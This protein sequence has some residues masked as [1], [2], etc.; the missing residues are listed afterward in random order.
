MGV[1]KRGYKR[2]VLGV[3]A[4]EWPGI[5]TLGYV[6]SLRKIGNE[7]STKPFIR[8]YISSAKLSVEELAHAAR[9]HWSI[10]VKLHC[11]LDV[12]L[13][14]DVCRIR[15]GDGAENFRRYDMLL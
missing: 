3:I 12:A 10:E 4:L 9:E 8:Y 14:E 5:T 6:V 2:F 11:K 1:Q 13:R 7:P 15:R